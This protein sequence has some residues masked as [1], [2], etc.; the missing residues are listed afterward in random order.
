VTGTLHSE[1]VSINKR[2]P[3]GLNGP[4][5]AFGSSRNSC[6]LSARWTAPF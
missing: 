2:D 3:G 1:S 5:L 4:R 6:R